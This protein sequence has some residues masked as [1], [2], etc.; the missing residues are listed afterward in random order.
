M[1]KELYERVL[2]LYEQPQKS[3]YLVRHKISNKLYAM[4]YLQ[5]DTDLSMY[6]QLQ[7]HPHHHMANIIE[8]DRDEEHC[9]IIEE[10]ING[11]T[12]EY[13]MST[14]QL[15]Y[16]QKQQIMLE[17]FEVLEHLHTLQPPIIHRDIKPANIMLENQRVKLIDFDIA[18]NVIP[19]KN[20]DT[21]IMGSVGY[22]PP[23]QFGFAQTD[24]R[25][26]VYALGMLIRELFTEKKGQFL[27]R[28]IIESCLQMD[29]QKRFASVS[30]LRKEFIRCSRGKR[31][32]RLTWKQRLQ[33]YQ[34]IG[35]RNDSAWVKLFVV[36]FM[37][38]AVWVAIESTTKE[39]DPYENAISRLLMEFATFIVFMMF[40]WIP[41]NSFHLSESMSLCRSPYRIIRIFGYC[42]LWFVI[43]CIIMLATVMF[44]GILEH[45][46]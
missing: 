37:I 2:T 41:S 26:D 29:P 31:V 38:A 11:T 7:K 9:Y 39:N 32:H 25:S 45:F 21:Q 20:K 33:N 28:M 27:Y 6:E 36:L 4:K 1:R 22:A 42:L 19:E 13:E 43:A 34:I 15:S 10:Y 40:L 46:L 14:N 3:I 12:L 17:L 44:S 18:R 30:H 5:S 35:L 23:E 16:L 8:C 24:Q